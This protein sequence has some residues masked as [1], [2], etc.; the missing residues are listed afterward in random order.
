MKRL[1]FLY[2]GPYYDPQAIPAQGKFT[3]LS[4]RY[5]GDIVAVISE[6]RHRT[7]QIGNFTLRGVYLPALSGCRP[8]GAT[9]RMARLRSCG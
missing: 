4:R 7:A 8:C 2:V 9:S 3:L 6:K 5:C 1:L